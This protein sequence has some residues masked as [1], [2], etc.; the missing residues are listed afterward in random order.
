MSNIVQ[1]LWIGRRLSKMEQLSVKSFQDHG[2]SYHLYTYGEVENIPRDTEVKD[3]NEILPESEIF[4][5]KNGSL[6]AFSNYFR[7]VL[8]HKKGGFWADTDMICVRPFKFEED[9]VISSEPNYKY[10]KHKITSSFIKLKKDS[11][12]TQEGINI[13]KKHK[14]EILSGRI[15]WSSG[16]RTVND[17]VSKYNLAKYVLPWRVTCSCNWSHIKSIVEPNYRPRNGIMSIFFKSKPPYNNLNKLPKIMCC[18]HLW[19]EMWVR[20]NMDK[21]E[22]FDYNSLYEQ[23]KRRHN[24]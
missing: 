20:K 18:I 4:T 21:N 1:S 15:E 13:Q 22:T 3:A 6:S 19:N 12:A 16:P 2:H 10:K 7:F 17:V 11:E 9:I 8:L 23:L 24:I 5:Y 14:V